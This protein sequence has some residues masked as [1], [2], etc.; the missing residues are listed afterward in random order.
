MIEEKAHHLTKI[1]E[2]CQ[3]LRKIRFGRRNE[4]E[5]SVYEP[6]VN[7]KLPQLLEGNSRTREMFHLLDNKQLCEKLGTY[8]HSSSLEFSRLSFLD[9]IKLLI[10][11]SE[12]R[13]LERMKA[14]TGI[15]VEKRLREV[16]SK[17]LCD[18]IN[19]CEEGGFVEVRNWVLYEM[20]KKKLTKEE[21]YSAKL[22]YKVVV[23]YIFAS[24][25]NHLKDIFQHVLTENGVCILIS[26]H[27]SLSFKFFLA[28]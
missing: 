28:K 24:K 17:I 23:E 9:T 15:E 22:G 1:I 8:L 4:G 10:L 6:L 27:F 21:F 13:G 2:Y 20:K 26:H 7:L 12:V 25:D 3:E 18:S 5:L 11:S 16:D 14:L 19:F